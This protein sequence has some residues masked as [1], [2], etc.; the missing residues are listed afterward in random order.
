MTQDSD[1]RRLDTG[2]SFPNLTIRMLGG[3]AINLPKDVTGHW[4]VVLFYRGYW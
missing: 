2:D 1:A 4:C 3:D